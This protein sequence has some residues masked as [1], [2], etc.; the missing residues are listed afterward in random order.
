MFFQQKKAGKHGTYKQ[1]NGL[2][3][4]N[5]TCCIL[6]SKNTMVIWCWLVVGVYTSGA[7]DISHLSTI[8]YL[9]MWHLPVHPVPW[10]RQVERVNH[11]LSGFKDYS[12]SPRSLGNCTQ[13]DYS[14]F[15]MGYSKTTNY[16]MEVRCN[17]NVV[18]LEEWRSIMNR[19]LVNHGTMIL[20]LYLVFEGKPKQGIPQVIWN[21]QTLAT[22]YLKSHN[23]S[24]KK[25]PSNFGLFD[26]LVKV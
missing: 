4:M 12:F 19:F 13:F 1:T 9:N 2:E 21:Q 14:N 23:S 15:Q 5:F 26:F 22:I 24:K 10:L 8:L 25:P 6:K 20:D 11:G 16:V 18:S 3:H 7:E 17:K